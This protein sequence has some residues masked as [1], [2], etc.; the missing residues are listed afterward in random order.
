MEW[1]YVTQT[2]GFP[3][4]VDLDEDAIGVLKVYHPRKRAS[5][6]NVGR[7]RH[8]LRVIARAAVYEKKKNQ[9]P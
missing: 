7:A 4:V 9:N 6:V 8:R 5:L 3:F 1:N 2:N